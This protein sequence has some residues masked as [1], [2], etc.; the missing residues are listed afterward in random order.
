M[1]LSEE[2]IDKLR[3]I[4]QWWDSRRA[5]DNDTSVI[6][7]DRANSKVTSIRLGGK[8]YQDAVA[9][10][11]ND[12]EVKNFNRLVELLLWERLE[13]SNEYLMKPDEL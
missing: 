12:P 2:E 6:K 7:F 1:N 11:E 8:L 10:A 13:K 5:F 9:L 4:I 3:R